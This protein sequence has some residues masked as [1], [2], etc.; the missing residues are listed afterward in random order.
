MLRR[1]VAL[2]SASTAIVDSWLDECHEK[3]ADSQAIGSWNG[4]GPYLIENNYL[5]GAG[6]NVMFGGSDPRFPGMAPSD[7]ILRRNHIHTPVA[8]QER[9]SKKNLLETKNVRRLLVEEN[10]LD[11]SWGDG[12]VGFGI[13]IKSA[14]QS[15]A[16]RWCSSSDVIVRRN[17][18]RHV[19]AGISVNGQ[20]GDRGNIDSVSRRI[21]ITENYVDSVRVGPYRGVGQLWMFLTGAR[22]VHVAQNTS[23]TA[24]NTQLQGSVTFGS[25]GKP[26]VLGFVFERNVMSRGRYVVSG[27]GGQKRFAECLPG[28]RMTG[29]VIVGNAPAGGGGGGGRR[30]GGRGGDQM[31]AGF[32]SVASTANAIGRAGVSRSEIDRIT[33]GVVVPR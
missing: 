25:P 31:P 6:E 10:V 4:A 20:G 24:P 28:A 8:W 33:S 21:E 5:A 26:S 18:M 12:Q 17:L 11:G 19:G 9:W 22:N 30:G 29:N 1:C 3:G 2:N 23:V 16:C 13:V 32:A 7:V 15:G 14:N 27:C